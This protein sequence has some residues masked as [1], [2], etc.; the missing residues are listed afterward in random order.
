MADAGTTHTQ[1]PAPTNPSRTGGKRWSSRMRPPPETLAFPQRREMWEAGGVDLFPG[2][3]FEDLPE[4]PFDLVFCSGV[5]HTMSGERNRTLYGRVRPLVADTGAF[6]IVTLLRGTTAAR[7]FAVQMLV[8]GNRGD[9][10]SED[11]YRHWLA[12]A[13]FHHGAGR[14]R[15]AT[16]GAHPRPS[17][18]TAPRRAEDAPVPLPRAAAVS[19]PG[20][21]PGFG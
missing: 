2:D 21:G 3:F 7:L 13:G 5:T 9:T 6:V 20:R 18:M 16:A 11:E 12:G 17:G 8:V 14:L 19:G 4:A 1:P 15:G 10:H